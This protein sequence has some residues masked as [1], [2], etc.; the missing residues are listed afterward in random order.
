MRILPRP[1]P[2]PARLKGRKMNSL[3]SHF[4]REF[5]NGARR[6]AA[7]LQ[8]LRAAVN[9]RDAKK[10]AEAL[11]GIHDALMGSTIEAQTSGIATLCAQIEREHGQSV[12]LSSVNRGRM[13]L[14]LAFDGR[15]PPYDPNRLQRELR[16]RAEKAF[17]PSLARL[18]L[19]KDIREDYVASAKAEAAE[20][21]V[22]SSV[23]GRLDEGVQ[24]LFQNAV[25]V[26]P[27]VPAYDWKEEIEAIHREEV[28]LT[29]FQTTLAGDGPSA[30]AQMKTEASKDTAKIC[31]VHSDDFRSVKWLGVQYFFSA[32]QAPVVRVLWEH[33]K[34]GTPDVGDT[35]LLSAVDPEAPPSRLNALF[36]NNSAWGT[37]IVPGETKGT[38]RLR[39]P[40]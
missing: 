21:I 27:I 39:D 17:P 19:P 4:V 18:I 31:T 30:T 26:G 10:T 32:N 8:Q 7:G 35:T 24:R 25:D 23:G 33:W 28:R 15:M 36:R 20:P 12:A 29:Q 5:F 34:R 11:D 22:I 37:L 14:L 1:S 40:K 16:A 13:I 6:I 38:H 2:R 3:S 9:D